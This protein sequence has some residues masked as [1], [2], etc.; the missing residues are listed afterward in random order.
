MNELVV[1][2]WDGYE[3]IDSGD[4]RRLERY[5][6]YTVVRPDPN[7]LWAPT[8]E[9]N[10]LWQNADAEYVGGEKGSEWVVRRGEMKNGWIL[11][12]QEMKLRLQLTP[13]RHVGVF[14]EQESNWKWIQERITSSK[15]ESPKVLNLFGYTGASSLV[16]SLSGAQ[17]THVDASKGTTHWASENAQ[18]SGCENIR[19][20]VDDALK[21]AEREVR[22]GTKY[23]MIMLDPPVFGRGPKGEIWR[24]EDK[25]EPLLEA[26]RDLLSDEPIGLLINTYAASLYPE[27]MLRLAESILKGKGLKLVLSTL[28]LEESSSK[29]SLQTGFVI[30]S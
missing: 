15:K 21:F 28:C 29:K 1:S 7:V 10:P 2:G 26:V 16:A 24:L 4:G 9:S 3:L 30:R 14:A 20:I 12:W 19:W 27:S 11:E 17:V 18:L 6:S 25:I 22:R 23:D 8:D 5:G 13:F